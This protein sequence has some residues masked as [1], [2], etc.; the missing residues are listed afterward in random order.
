MK[1]KIFHISIYLFISLGYC[2]SLSAQT[3]DLVQQFGD[4]GG[5]SCQALITDQQDNIYISGGFNDNFQLGNTELSTIGGID[6]YLSKLDK[7]GMVQWTVSGGGLE[8]DEIADLTV[9]TDNNVYCSGMYW[10]NADFGDT[11]LSVESSSR[12]IFIIKYTSE[13]RM[14]WA[15]SFDGTGLK[16]LSDIVMDDNNDLYLTGYFENTLM[17][18]DLT[19]IATSDTDMFVAKMSADG[20]LIWANRAGLEGETLGI[21]LAVDSEKNVVVGGHYQGKVAFYEDTIQSN[22]PDFDVFISKFDAN[23][24]VLWGKKAG[25]V[26]PSENTEI[27]VSKEDKIYITGT[28]LGVLKLS[29]TIELQTSGF[30]KNIFLLHYDENGTPLWAKSIGGLEDEEAKDMVLQ[31]ETIAI[32]GNFLGNMTVDNLSLQH[33][34]P[35]FNGFVAGFS[36]EGSAK[37][38]EKMTASELLLGE[39]VDINQEEQVVTAGIFTQSAT[40]NQENYLSNGNFDIFLARLNQQVTPLPSI[41][42]ESPLFSI[43]PNPARDYIFIKTTEKDFKIKLTDLKG[44][45]IEEFQST[46]FINTQHLARGV[47][48]ISIITKQAS[49]INKLILF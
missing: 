33:N 39:E 30:N 7:N 23:G 46:S 1:Y 16:Q 48:Y 10:L 9:D 17:L 19:L 27:A 26:Y 6:I 43:F 42:E 41:R 5:E 34:S 3:W 18:D 32:S 12:G 44:C 47:Y 21:S 49:F 4:N 37:W 15:K 8:N 31:N 36:L 14:L 38:L 13:G 28:F 40:F 24:Q 45:F 11:T 2:C 35:V 20:E 29:E 25:G 22:T